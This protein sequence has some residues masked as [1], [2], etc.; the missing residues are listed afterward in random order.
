MCPMYTLVLEELE[1]QYLSHSDFFTDDNQCLTDV[2][3]ASQA[4]EEEGDRHEFE[5]DK[6]QSGWVEGRLAREFALKS[7]DNVRRGLAP[8]LY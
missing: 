5:R 3:M 8:T 4:S 7:M 1:R 6:D 2:I